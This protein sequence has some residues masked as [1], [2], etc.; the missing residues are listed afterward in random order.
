MRRSRLA[1]SAALAAVV[2]VP[3]AGCGTQ[4]PAGSG[5]TAGSVRPAQG[6]SWEEFLSRVYQEADTGIYVANGDETFT[7]LEQLREF[8]EEN[9]R[10]QKVRESQGGLAVMLRD[11]SPARWGDAEKFNITYCVSTTFGT[12]HAAVVAA[13]A[14]AANAWGSVAAVRFV[15]RRELDGN[16]NTA[17]NGVVFDVRP[18][19]GASYMARAFFPGD[20]RSA[21]SVLIDSSAF[22]TTI[23]NLTLT[24]ILRHEL[25]HTL[26]F[27]HEHTRPQAGTCFEDSNWEALTDYDSSSVMHYPQCNGTGDWSLTLTNLDIEGARALYGVA[28]GEIRGFGGKSLDADWNDPVANG[29]KVQLWD[30]LNGGNQKWQLMADGSIRG[31]GGKCLDADWNEPVANGTKVQLW[32]CNGL[33]QQ[34]WSVLPDGTIRGFGGKCLDADWNWPVANGTKLQL[35]DCNGGDQQKWSVIF[36]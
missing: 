15:H 30:W 17:Q 24:G 31:F 6:M 12:R 29:T 1:V 9:F 4:E 28:T 3:L 18:V 20:P 14:D 7:D 26:G 21:R 33:E 36:Q 22:T 10:E 19:S 11:D 25:G 32:D 23:P 2:S 13:M 16:C 35:W 27:R 8:Y 34:R 5:E